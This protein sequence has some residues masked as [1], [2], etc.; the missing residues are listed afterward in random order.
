MSSADDF[1][2]SLDAYVDRRIGE[3]QSGVHTADVNTQGGSTRTDLV[4]ALQRLIRETPLGVAAGDEWGQ[5]AS[6]RPR[7]DGQA[8]DA[9]ECCS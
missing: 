7:R 1:M 9:A 5:G 4:Q 3:H 2:N 6:P 8:R